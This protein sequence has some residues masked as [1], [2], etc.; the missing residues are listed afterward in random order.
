MEREGRI[1][2]AEP[3]VDIKPKLEPVASD[4]FIK[5]SQ[6]ALRQSS[7]LSLTK[8]KDQQESIREHH[9]GVIVIIPIHTDK[10]LSA[11]EHALGSLANQGEKKGQLSIV[12][13]DISIVIA[14]N[15]ISN[16]GRIK[17]KE[18]ARNLQLNDFHFA[19][20]RPTSP[21]QK[22]PAYARN[23]AIKLVEKLAHENPGYRKD[24][25]LMMDSDTALLPGAVRE[26]EKTYRKHE[27]TV[28]VTSRNIGVPNIDQPT[29]V[30]YFKEVDSAQNER[31]LPKLY[32]QGGHVDIASIVAFGSDVA[33]K[34]CGLFVD[35]N[36]ITRLLK[37][38]V[39]MPHGSSEDMLFTVALNNMGEIWHNP[40]AV[41]L[42]QAR[43][44]PEQTRIQRINWGQDHA[45][46]FADLVSMGLVPKGLRVLE[47]RGKTWVEWKVPNS[48]PITGLIINPNQLKDLALKLKENAPIG[49]KYEIE[50]GIEILKRITQYID[51]VRS[52]SPTNIRTNLPEPIQPNPAQTRFR[53]EALTGLLAGNILGMHEIQRIDKGIIPQ[54]VFFG[55]RQAAAWK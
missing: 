53:P 44:T 20:A 7:I 32:K 45:L 9:P 43:E 49:S 46:L 35:R 54:V 31:L 34:T 38:F 15:G 50:K 23:I 29:Q 27:G 55:V 14:D 37:P 39:T 5:N 24:G 40:K 10:R 16:A 51:L 19:D 42:D 30:T 52:Q 47:P 17:I 26:L 41:L 21:D 2:M 12:I 1:S 48:D 33:T 18:I 22:N 11:I 36:T 4:G 13:A 8:P 6:T 25:I 3:I 28:A